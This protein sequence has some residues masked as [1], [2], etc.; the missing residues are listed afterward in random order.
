MKQKIKT[1][2]LV[3]LERQR[4]DRELMRWLSEMGVM[5]W[6]MASLRIG[7]V[8]EDRKIIRVHPDTLGFF[9]KDEKTKKFNRER[10]DE[11]S[12]AGTRFEYRLTKGAIYS[13]FL[14]TRRYPDK[15]LD[16]LCGYTVEEIEEI[17]DKP[18]D[19][20]LTFNKNFGRIKVSK[21]NI[22]V[23]NLRTEKTTV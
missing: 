17:V 1:M 5:P 12:F 23:K 2:N 22:K 7:D 13:G 10:T 9:L 21:A 16:P 6:E 19:F 18:Y 4:E 14:F 15:R 11:I 20:L 8:D 3:P